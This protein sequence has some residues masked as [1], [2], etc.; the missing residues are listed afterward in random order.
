MRQ[1]P[2]QP[3][4]SGF[5]G[6]IM[7][8][9]A[10]GMAVG[11]GLM[12][13]EAIGRSLMGGRNQPVVPSENRPSGDYQPSTTNTDMGGQNFGM[14]DAASWDDAGSSGAEGGD[15]WDVLFTHY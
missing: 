5:G 4:G 14:N 3:V 15:N 10:T 9:V 11:A 7:G 13:A 2:G 8:G 6:K 12:E 1:N